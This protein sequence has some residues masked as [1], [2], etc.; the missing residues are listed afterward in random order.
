MSTSS[1]VNPLI[2]VI[3]SPKFTAS[4]PI[5]IEPFSRSA[6]A[7]EPALIVTAPDVTVKWFV[8]NEAIPLFDVVA[9]SPATVTVVPE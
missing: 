7:T 1:E 3:V 2:S 9:S 6:F 8:S 4:L 5:V